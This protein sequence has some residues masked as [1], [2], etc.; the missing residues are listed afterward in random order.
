MI[1]NRLLTLA[2]VLTLVL[3]IFIAL[4]A[5]AETLDDALQSLVNYYQQNKP[6]PDYWEEVVGLKQAEQAGKVGNFDFTSWSVAINKNTDAVEYASA[7]LALV[8]IDADPEAYVDQIGTEINLVQCLIDKQQA[9]GSFGGSVNNTIFAITALDQVN[10]DN[11]EYDKVKAIN[12]LIGQQKADGGFALSGNVGDSDV[13]GMALV[14]LSTDQHA[15]DDAIAKAINFLR[16]AQNDSGGFAS[17]GL[18]NAESTASVI[19]GLLACNQDIT[20]W[21]KNDNNIINALFAFRLA[22]GS[23]SHLHDGSSSDMATRQVLMAV[24]ALANHGYGNFQLAGRDDGGEQVGTSQVEVRVEGKNHTLKQGSVTVNGTA[25]DAL[26]QLVGENNVKLNQWGM[27]DNILDESGQTSVISGVDTAWKYYV[28]RDDQIETTAFSV[29]P[30]SYNLQSGDQVIFYIGAYDNTTWVDKTYFPLVKFTR[31]GQTLTVS[32]QGQYFDWNINDLATVPVEGAT[33]IL[34]DQPYTAEKG[35]VKVP[36]ANERSVLYQVYKEHAAGYPELVRTYGQVTITSD[37]GDIIENNTISVY[38]QVLGK[39]KETLFSGTVKMPKEKANPI[40]ALKETGLSYDTRYG[41]AYVYKIEGLAEDRS[42]TAGWKFQVNG[43]IPSVSAI[44]QVLRDGDDVVWFWAVD[45]ND[46]ELVPVIE[47]PAAPELTEE[48]KQDIERSR[49]VVRN[50]LKNIAEQINSAPPEHELYHI[51]ELDNSQAVVIKTDSLMSDKEWEQW[52]AILSAN[53]VVV[54]QQVKAGVEATIS[55]N[56]EEV[57]LYI[58]NG[59]LAKDTAISIKEKNTTD[60]VEP[61]THSLV[62]SVY[63]FT[64]ND[65]TFGKPVIIKIKLADGVQAPEDL[66][67][68]WYNVKTQS[69]VP[70]PTVVNVTAGEVSGLINHFTD[71]AVLQRNKQPSTFSDVNSDSFGWAEKP[72]QYLSIKGVVSGGGDNLFHPEQVVTRAEFVSMLARALQLQTD[73]VTTKFSDVDPNH[74]C[75]AEISAAVEAG[76]ISGYHDGTFR[77]D[78]PVTREQLAVFLNRVLGLKPLNQQLDFADQAD[79]APWAWDSVWVAANNQLVMGYADGTFK[80]KDTAN[81]AETAVFIYRL[82]KL[83]PLAS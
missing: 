28:I 4:P 53:Q 62:S 22:N 7:I 2:L 21:T 60:N 72:I 80:P 59:A 50:A 73:T 30:D 81:R 17:F 19:R 5:E 10:T 23:F 52:R 9:N 8:A 18:E 24:A 25:L 13:T 74:W 55:D 44:D 12:Y 78:N 65:T 57:S 3:N 77:P 61:S 54:E 11:Y 41:G 51:V 75:A 79:I 39:S 82:L 6:Q 27:I 76:L 32:V 15:A 45:A 67:L 37:G 46:G 36:L 68:A 14:A 38:I 31:D 29:G 56:A 42:S 20:S 71:F 26:K 69:W 16:M 63:S 1:K 33:V 43:L 47:F 49:E 83:K 48:R 35:Q 70:V 58:G 64:P 40:Q 66:V 34:N